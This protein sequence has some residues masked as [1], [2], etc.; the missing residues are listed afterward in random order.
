MGKVLHL[1]VILLIAGR[2]GNFASGQRKSFFI[3]EDV[4]QFL[5]ESRQ[6]WQFTVVQ[7]VL[8]MEMK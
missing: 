5:K 1:M 3:S 8:Y 7:C 6:E 4:Y 2:T